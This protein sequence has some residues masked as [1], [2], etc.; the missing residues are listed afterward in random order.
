LI[1]ETN[2]KLKAKQRIGLTSLSSNLEGEIIFKG[3]GFVTPQIY[4]LY[5]GK[6]YIKI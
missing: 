1:L 6:V 3:V 2:Q 5:L 4:I